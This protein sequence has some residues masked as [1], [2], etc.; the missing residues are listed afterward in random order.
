MKRKLTV[1]ATLGLMFFPSINPKAQC[2]WIERK[3]HPDTDEPINPVSI[4]KPFLGSYIC[5][6]EML[7]N[8]LGAPG[9][10]VCEA[11]VNGL[12]DVKILPGVSV[13]N[14]KVCNDGDWAARIGPSC[15]PIDLC[16]NTYQLFVKEFYDYVYIGLLNVG[17]AAEGSTRLNIP[18]LYT[19]FYPHNRGTGGINNPNPPSQEIYDINWCD[20][21]NAPFPS[22]SH[23]YR[24]GW[25]N[26]VN[27]YDATHMA[28]YSE[29]VTNIDNYDEMVEETITVNV[30]PVHFAI[31]HIPA[32]ATHTGALSAL[33]HAE[34]DHNDPAPAIAGLDSSSAQSYYKLSPY[35]DFS[36]VSAL[37]YW[38]KIELPWIRF[39]VNSDLF[40]RAEVLGLPPYNLAP[41]VRASANLK[42]LATELLFDLSIPTEQSIVRNADSGNPG[43]SIGSVTTP[44]Q[45]KIIGTWDPIQHLPAPL[46]L[47]VGYPAG[48]KYKIFSVAGNAIGEITSTSSHNGGRGRAIASWTHPQSSSVTHGAYSCP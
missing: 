47:E 40:V 16:N 36:N 20:P 28:P 26:N 5:E 48:A 15:S 29:V 30:V 9:H 14:V 10:G 6:D 12:K 25:Y 39:R 46:I 13:L 23:N 21:L 34:A 37:S 24:F 41:N 19:F 4:G 38:N 27:V 31:I 1:L 22:M 33:N 8:K 11:Y 44:I 45:P 32:W 2:E 42:V 17:S 3:D 43:P 7:G 35:V 18:N